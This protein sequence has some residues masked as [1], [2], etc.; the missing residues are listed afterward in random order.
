M[1][2]LMLVNPRKRKKAKR[3]TKSKFMLKKTSARKR[4]EITDE[5]PHKRRRRSASKRAISR[6][7]RRSS[8]PAG[9]GG[10]KGITNQLLPAV[11]AAGGALALDVMWAYVPLPENLKTGPMRHVVKAAGAI[12]LGMLA[13]MVM[14]KDT[15]NQLA[16]GALTVVLHGAMRDMAS[17]FAPAIKL[18]D[19]GEFE[20]SEGVGEYVDESMGYTGSGYNPEQGM[21][22]QL[23][24]QGMGM[25]MQDI[26]A[27]AYDDM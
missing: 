2:E 24:D 7:R 5:N 13:G 27:Y 22:M 18:G 21:G 20:V 23:T 9:L 16:T 1:A 19:V 26:N 14:K 12:G 8:K 10:I 6:M 11:T 15:A 4:N 25:Y 17:R 3:K